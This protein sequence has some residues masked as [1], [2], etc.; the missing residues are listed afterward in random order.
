MSTAPLALRPEGVAYAGRRAD[1]LAGIGA[2]LPFVVAYVPF[3]LVLGVTLR[4]HG[5][6][7]AGWLG[8]FAVYG[9]SAQLGAIRTLERS[10]VAAAVFTGLVINARL[11]VYSAGLARQWT[12]QP[13]WFRT[14]AAL[15]V[16][17]PTYALAQREAAEQP[18]PASQRV[19]FLASGVTLTVGWSAAVAVGVLA[20]ARIGGQ[21]LAVTVPLCLVALVGGDLRRPGPRRVI[22]VAAASGLVL[23]NLPAGTGILVATLAGCCAGWRRDREHDVPQGGHR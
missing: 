8:T 13:R 5:D 6:P 20:G 18:Y 22:V 14:V 19:R 17:D 7:L 1:V 11:I 12:S 21:H 16:I 9:G 23:A 4:E 2:M 3:A 15:M 10:G